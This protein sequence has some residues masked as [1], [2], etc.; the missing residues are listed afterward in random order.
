MQWNWR[1]IQALQVSS[2]KQGRRL[3]AIFFLR[4]ITATQHQK[5]WSGFTWTAGYTPSRC[6]GEILRRG[7]CSPGCLCR[8][9][10]PPWQTC[11]VLLN[12]RSAIFTCIF[13]LF[14]VSNDPDQP[15]INQNVIPHLDQDLTA[16]QT[17]VNLICS[18]RGAPRDT[19][20]EIPL[21]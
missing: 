21:W 20:H 18:A 6:F 9:S 5:C 16:S 8:Y 19:V 2:G 4:L 11:L 7:R 1:W 12:S 17:L 3:C 13:S 10:S 14:V 15:D